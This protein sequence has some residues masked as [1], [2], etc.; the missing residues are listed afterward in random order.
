MTIYLWLQQQCTQF[1][2]AIEY[3]R[4]NNALTHFLGECETTRIVSTDC[5]KAFI[6]LQAKLRTRESKL[7]GY[8]KMDQLNSIDAYTTSPAES[9]NKAITH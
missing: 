4:S 2:M 1:E 6:E 7:A 9:N 8:L 3:R 5:I